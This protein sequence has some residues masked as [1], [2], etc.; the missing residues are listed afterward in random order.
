MPLSRAQSLFAKLIQACG[1]EAP[2]WKVEE[3]ATDVTRETVGIYR[4]RAFIIVRAHRVLH[5]VVPE[6]NV[7]TT[8][9]QAPDA[10]I[11]AR[12]RSS[13]SLAAREKAQLFGRCRTQLA[14]TRGRF[15]RLEP[16][17]Q[18]Q[19]ISRDR[20]VELRPRADVVVDLLEPNAHN[21]ATG[22]IS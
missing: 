21:A 18:S 9:V 3:R 14:R 4:R 15:A 16:E 11:L 17:V 10:E 6:A 20:R 19:A 2:L 8:S 22:G 5:V 12:A 13:R 7:E 1:R